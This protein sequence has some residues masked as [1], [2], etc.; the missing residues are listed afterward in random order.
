[1]AIILLVLKGKQSCKRE[2]M[3]VLGELLFSA[4]EAKLSMIIH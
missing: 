4:M 3:V 1:M 2:L